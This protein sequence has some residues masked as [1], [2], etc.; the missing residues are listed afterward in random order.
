MK[1]TTEYP[2]V[3]YQLRV[4]TRVSAIVIL[5][6]VLVG[7]FLPRD[8]KI[9]RDILVLKSENDVAVYLQQPSH[10]PNW[11]YVQDGLLVPDIVTSPASLFGFTIDY[12]SGDEGYISVASFDSMHVVFSVTPTLAQN[13]VDNIIR[14]TRLNDAEVKITW[15]I[16]GHLESGLLSPYLALFANS[17]A[18]ANFEKSL[19]SLKQ[20]LEL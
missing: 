10:W 15:S 20:E 6:A 11:L 2:K 9:E 7:F 19:L 1:K 5:L 4:V 13:S 14:W 18:G 17:I 12:I 3:F 16:S 8:Y